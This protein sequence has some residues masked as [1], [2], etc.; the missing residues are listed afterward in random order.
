MHQALQEPLCPVSLEQGS[1]LGHIS[2]VVSDAITNLRDFLEPDQR[3]TGSDVL[4][5]DFSLL[6]QVSLL[7]CL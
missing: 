1:G 3:S 6:P 7:F 4:M 5:S 2:L